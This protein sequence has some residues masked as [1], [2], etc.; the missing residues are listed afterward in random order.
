MPKQTKKIPIRNLRSHKC[1]D[2]I[3]HYEVPGYTF[4]EIL[5]AS[6]RDRDVQRESVW[7]YI[8]GK[9]SAYISAVIRGYAE[10]SS[11]HLV[12]IEKTIYEMN[13]RIA[14]YNDPLDIEYRERLKSFQEDG[15]KYLHI[16]GGNRCDALEDWD[17]DLVPLQSGNYTVQ[18]FNGI[19]GQMENVTVILDQDEYYTKSVLLNLGGDYAKLVEAVDSAVFNWFEYPSLTSEE[20]KDLFIKLNDNEDLTTEEFR[21]CNTSLY[22]RNIRALNDALKQEFLDADF[23]TKVNSIRYK[24]CAYLAAW[25]NYYSWHG[26]IDPYAT[27]TLDA[28]YVVGTPNN[29]KVTKN[30]DSFIK[31]LNNI[32]LPFMRDT[33]QKRKNL[34]ATGGRNILHDFFWLFVEIERLN[35]SVAPSNYKRLFDAYMAW[36]DEKCQ[37]K[38]CKY[39]TGQDRETLVKFYDLYGAN[40]WYKAKHR[41]EHIREDIIPMLVEQGIAVVKDE[42]RL[43]DPRWRIPIWERDGRVCPLSNR[44]ISREEAK[45]PEITSLDHITPHSL[46]GKTVQE[47]IQLVFKDQ[48]LA[49][50]DSV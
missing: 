27:S 7:R 17:N 50:S 4:K 48:N 19:T 24:F 21:N 12:N 43:A 42:V 47:N 39:N 25:S 20:R 37:D 13:A 1:L 9:Q 46:G 18:E 23:I 31:F 41:V 45:D 36:Y 28:D 2:K 22:C 3:P 44:P 8:P 14:M 11:F 35:G 10:L 49:K 32:F 15:W 5:K 40:T 30:Y 6:G 26:Q 29:T 34:A 33:V 38:T 16:D